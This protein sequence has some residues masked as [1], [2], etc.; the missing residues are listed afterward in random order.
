MD[1]DF[2]I[3]CMVY[4]MLEVLPHVDFC[5]TDYNVNNFAIGILRTTKLSS[6]I[7]C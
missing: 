1:H 7:C 3:L 2:L 4:K 5:Q 6:V